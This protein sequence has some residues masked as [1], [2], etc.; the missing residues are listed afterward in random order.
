M[1]DLPL[2]DAAVSKLPEDLREEIAQRGR[3]NLYYFAKAI[4]GFRDMT[5]RAHGD[6]TQFLQRDNGQYDMAL[7]PRGTFKTHVSCADDLRCALIDPNS[8][9]LIVNENGLN[10][11]KMLGL[12]SQL[13][14][15]NPVVRALYSEVIPKDTRKVKWNSEELC[16]NRDRITT[17]STFESVGLTAALASRHYERIKIDDPISRDAVASDLVMQEAIERLKTVPKLLSNYERDHIRYIGTCWSMK[18][19]VSWF[20]ETYHPTVFL[21]GAYDDKGELLFPE[22]MGAK[23]LAS[24]RDADEYLYSANYLNDPRPPAGAELDTGLLAYAE[25]I[26]SRKASHVIMYEGKD[27]TKIKRKVLL[28]N[29]DIT[30]TVDLAPAEGLSSDRNA[31]VVCGITPWNEAIVLEA[32]AERC[33]PSKVIDKLFEINNRFHPRR[34]GIEAVAYQ[35]AFKFFL[36]DEMTRRDSWFKIEEIRPERGGGGKRKPHIR[37][38]QPLLKHGRLFI[39]PQMHLLRDE[40]QSYPLGKHDDIIDALAMHLRLWKTQLSPD[41]FARVEKAER[42]LLHSEREQELRARLDM[43]DQD[44]EGN[45]LEEFDDIDL[46][47]ALEEEDRMIFGGGRR[48]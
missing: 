20:R 2:L 18:D 22:R 44:D 21:R 8:C 3:T 24:E 46:A 25:V 41:W 27:L 34:V 6:F 47:V 12:I 26:E 9:T 5:A 10:A 38:L 1:Q 32:W 37:G 31:I 40:M 29:M 11:S 30:V 42:D 16:L 28:T 7:M 45:Y 4:C 43:T 17:V 19:T 13:L 35:K 15:M 39:D 23:W 14:T 48:G 36:T 33:V